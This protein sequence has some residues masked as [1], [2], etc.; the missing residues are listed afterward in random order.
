MKVDFDIVG[1]GPDGTAAAQSLN[2]QSAQSKT[3]HGSSRH[4]SH[5]ISGYETDGYVYAFAA[6]ENSIA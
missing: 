3:R 4:R 6:C 2:K 1:A 5:A